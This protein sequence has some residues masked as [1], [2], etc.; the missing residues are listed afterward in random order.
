LVRSRKSVP[1]TGWGEREETG[2]GGTEKK[3]GERKKLAGGKLERKPAASR[4]RGTFR[5][6]GKKAESITKKKLHPKIGKLKNA[7]F[8]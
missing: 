3:G 1:G 2:V 7:L 5:R 6:S 8:P 4:G